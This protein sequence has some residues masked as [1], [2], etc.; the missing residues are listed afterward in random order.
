MY[1]KCVRK[2]YSGFQPSCHNTYTRKYFEESACCWGHAAAK[3][4]QAPRHKPEG[5]ESRIGGFSFYW[6]NP[7]SRNTA[8]GS[9][10][11]PTETSTRNL[12][13]G[14]RA[15]GAWGWQPYRH[16]WADFLDKMWEPQRLTTLWAFTDCY[17]G[18]FTFTLIYMLLESLN[19]IW[20]DSVCLIFF[21]SKL[22]SGARFFI[23][24]VTAGYDNVWRL[25]N[26]CRRE[27]LEQLNTEC[28]GKDMEE[29][30]DYREI[31]S[32]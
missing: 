11:P 8:L 2:N 9:T 12:P 1:N 19:K 29:A 23:Q 28:S 7:P 17:R 26:L 3:L 18:S 20:D 27:F 32:N 16:L 10:H 6:P 22:I 24:L 14:Q 31:V 25:L 5:F 4:V 30:F 21:V 15:A 13:G